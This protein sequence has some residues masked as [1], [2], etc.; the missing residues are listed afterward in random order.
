MISNVLHSLYSTGDWEVGA[1]PT[2]Y[3]FVLSI[4]YPWNA[5]NHNLKV[6][7][8]AHCMHCHSASAAAN[9]S[10]KASM[11]DHHSPKVLGSV[12]GCKNSQQEHRFRLILGKLPKVLL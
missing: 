8:T 7:G 4:D 6:S 3:P 5:E 2:M 11:T 10:D 12:E 9:P 1:Y